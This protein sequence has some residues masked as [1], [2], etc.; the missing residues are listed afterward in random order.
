MDI[1]RALVGVHG[2]QVHHVANDV[3]V[4]HDAVAAVNVPREAR[5]LERLAARVA[6]EDRCDLR[7]GR[8]RLGRWGRTR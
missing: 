4:V 1:V 8:A 5:D 6:L 3:V 2:L 7:R